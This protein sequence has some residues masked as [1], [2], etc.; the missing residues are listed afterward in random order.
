MRTC[1]QTTSYFHVE[2]LYFCSNFYSQGVLVLHKLFILFVILDTYYLDNIRGYVSDVLHQSPCYYKNNFT[3]W[4][5]SK[6][7]PFVY[8]PEPVYSQTFM[9]RESNIFMCHRDISIFLF[10]L[11]VYIIFVTTSTCGTLLFS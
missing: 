5:V 4:K 10:F 1:P 11:S 2:S 3:I 8:F 7:I 9:I 6:I